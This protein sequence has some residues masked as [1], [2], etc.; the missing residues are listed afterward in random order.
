MNRM[1]LIA[2]FALVSTSAACATTT[3]T[4]TPVVAATKPST[5]TAEFDPRGGRPYPPACGDETPEQLTVLRQQ[6]AD[7]DYW[8][9]TPSRNIDGITFKC[10]PGSNPMMI[11][12]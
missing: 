8:K 12:E 5:P 4:A 6:Q 11:T 9:V 10:G 7:P 2:V 3:K 1:M